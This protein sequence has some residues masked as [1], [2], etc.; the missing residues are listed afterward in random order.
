MPNRASPSSN[1]LLRPDVIEAL[2][3]FGDSAVLAEAHRRFDAFVK[4]PSSLVPALREPVL[5]MVGHTA[6]AAT[7]DKLRDLGIRATSTEEKLR[8]FSALAT[9]ADP[10]LVARTVAFADSG[11]VPNGRITL[12]LFSASRGSENPELVYEKVKPIEAKLAA[13]I[14]P[15]GLGP[16]PLVAAAAGSRDPKTADA[17][18]AAA[19]S[20]S[21]V[22]A[23]IWAARVADGIQTAADLRRRAVPQIQAWL[24]KR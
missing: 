4:D 3:R 16:S 13:R 18:L 14:P 9:A 10:A 5:G 12:Y 19:S 2:G 7:W 24:A 6:D 22:G 15:G 21:S 23:H 11:E 1:S 8:Y 17:V 20:N